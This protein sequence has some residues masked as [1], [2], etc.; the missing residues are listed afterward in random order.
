MKNKTLTLVLSVI[1]IASFF[2]ACSTTVEVST[3]S[4][5]NKESA[6]LQ[7]AD[8]NYDDLDASIEK[9]IIATSERLTKSELT[10]TGH[11]L[12]GAEIENNNLIA[13][14]IAGVNNF[15]FENE[16]LTSISAT[17]AIPTV[18]KYEIN[19]DNK[20]YTEIE[21]LE[22]N[23]DADFKTEVVRLF[24]NE[25]KDDALLADT[26]YPEIEN[27]QLEQAFDYLDFIDRESTVKTYI[28][29]DYIKTIDENIFKEK[30]K[31]FPNWE[32][33]LELLENGERFIYSTNCVSETLVTCTKTNIDG[34]VI[35]KFSLDSNGMVTNLLDTIDN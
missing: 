3:I 5:K 16:I 6:P 19:P 12:L 26:R 28:E 11:I 13:Y 30:A 25:Y 23:K 15:G 1:L 33:S 18:I 2:T 9:S 22:P 10:T 35:S 7:I 32:G 24:P 29:K 31:N 8:I 21:Y 14:I 34:N 4:V 27:M 17:G 20:R